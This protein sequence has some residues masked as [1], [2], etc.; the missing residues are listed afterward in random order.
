MTIRYGAALRRATLGIAVLTGLSA[1][2]R[3]ATLAGVDPE[4][5]RQGGDSSEVAKVVE[6]YHA[7]EVAGDSLAMLAL[8]DEDV[9]ILE[10]GGIE[11]KAEFRSHHIAADI[12][13]LR[14]VQIERS[15][16]RVRTRGEAAWATSTSI[17]QGNVNGRI[18]NSA[19]AEL[20]VLAR[21]PAGWKIT[22][23]HWSSRAR[24]AP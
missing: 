8:L 3:A 11:T 12:A 19:G 14:A 20:M 22:A 18:V 15:P 24:R 5:A 23:I 16:I 7:A 17:A 1:S 9:L 21:T 2:V 6:A 13:Y 4:H 10:S